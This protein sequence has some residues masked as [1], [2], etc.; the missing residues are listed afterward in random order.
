M[1]LFSET[2][3][4][5]NP[6]IWV[7]KAVITAPFLVPVYTLEVWY[8]ADLEY[9]E[10]KKHMETSDTLEVLTDLYKKLFQS[11]EDGHEHPRWVKK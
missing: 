11:E 4:L 9:C 10:Q 3:E 5:V 7:K 6:C 8:I 2:F 1:R